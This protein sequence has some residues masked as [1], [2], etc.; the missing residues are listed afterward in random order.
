[1]APFITIFERQELERKIFFYY[2]VR[3]GHFLIGMEKSE[4]SSDC[5]VIRVLMEAQR[6]LLQL[7]RSN[8][9]NKQHSASGHV[10]EF[11]VLGAS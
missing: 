4:M 11:S 6:R 2:D 9:N 3:V 8:F 1:L 5:L 10:N 7:A